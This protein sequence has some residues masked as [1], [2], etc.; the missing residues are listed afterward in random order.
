MKLGH[1]RQGKSMQFSYLV[2]GIALLG[3]S[4][5]MLKIGWPRNGEVKTFAT[6]EL[7]TFAIVITALAGAVLVLQAVLG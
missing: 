3:G 7:Y 2:A 1:P 5:F 6:S 4:G